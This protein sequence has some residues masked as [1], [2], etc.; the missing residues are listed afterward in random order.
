[1]TL[2]LDIQHDVSVEMAA[3]QQETFHNITLDVSGVKRYSGIKRVLGYSST[4][5]DYLYPEAGQVLC[6]LYTARMRFAYKTTWTNV[7]LYI[8]PGIKLKLQFAQFRTSRPPT[9]FISEN[10][11]AQQCKCSY[12]KYFTNNIL[13]YNVIIMY[14]YNMWTIFSLL[15]NILVSVKIARE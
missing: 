8:I 2:P 10:I 12:G 1:M 11:N 6:I 3:R 4:L 5:K 15:L 7:L 9:V 14:R 13:M